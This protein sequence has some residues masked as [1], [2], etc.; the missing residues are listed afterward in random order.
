MS[1]KIWRAPAP[2]RTPGRNPPGISS[3][4][5]RAEG[6]RCVLGPGLHL[7]ARAPRSTRT[8]RGMLPRQDSWSEPAP[9]AAPQLYLLF[10]ERNY[11][12]EKWLELLRLILRMPPGLW[13]L[14]FPGLGI[15]F[16]GFWHPTR[17]SGNESLA[18]GLTGSKPPGEN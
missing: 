5:G 10:S 6:K 17:N 1:S 3:C 13:E 8:D 11:S 2:Q 12:G 14:R 15:K 7:L 18:Q 4:S 9:I 16:F